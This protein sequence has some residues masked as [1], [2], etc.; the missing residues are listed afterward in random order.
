LA[1]DKLSMMETANLDMRPSRTS[2]MKYIIIGPPRSGKSTRAR[3]LRG[4]G[5]PTFCTDPKSL[6]K[7]PEKD[8]IYLPEG[9]GWSKGSQYICDWWFTLSGDWCVEGIATVRALR[10]YILKFNDLPKDCHIV[11]LTEQYGDL[12]EGQR[13]MKKSIQN[14]WNEIEPAVREIIRSRNPDRFITIA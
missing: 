9:L 14:I 5:V 1:Y 7:E 4:Q 10:K 3:S 11:R 8:V 6:V 12:L 13:R 2:K